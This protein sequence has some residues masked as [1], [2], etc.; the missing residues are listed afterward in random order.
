MHTHREN[1]S[2]MMQPTQETIYILAKRLLILIM[3]AIIFCHVLKKADRIGI[4]SYVVDQN[5]HR[6]QTF[7][8]VFTVYL[9]HQTPSRFSAKY[10]CFISQNRLKHIYDT[11]TGPMIW[12]NLL[13]FRG[14][15]DKTAFRESW[16]NNSSL[17]VYQN[18]YEDYVNTL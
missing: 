15:G 1:I 12:N 3:D 10:E 17:S 18:K 8:K 13:F 6:R 11:K 14:C 5:K 7:M 4:S 9:K 16:R 2:K